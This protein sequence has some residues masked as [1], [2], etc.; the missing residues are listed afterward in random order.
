MSEFVKPKTE[1]VADKN[2]VEKLVNVHLKKDLHGDEEICEVCHGTGLVIRENPYGLSDDPDKSRMFPYSHQTLTF[3]P[4]C[5][6]GI[7]HRCNLCGGIIERGY[8]KHN[9]EQQRELDRK[10]FYQRRAK[11]LNDAELAPSEIIK[12]MECFFSD[13]YGRNDGF[14]MDWDDFFEYWAEEHEPS[15]IR[16]EFVWSTEP[17]KINIDAQGIVED[18]TE[19]L[20]EDAFY[21]IPSERIIELQDYLNKW[22]KECGVGTTYFEGKYKVRIPWEDYDE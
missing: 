12:N 19:D 7:I 22:C 5:F 8:T 4:H 10:Q 16:P 20:Y 13:E 17:V 18:A 9:C 2:Y 15:D 1:Y 14:F 3:C 21:D 11:E 6:N